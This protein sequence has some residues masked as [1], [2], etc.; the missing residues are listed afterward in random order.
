[1]KVIMIQHPHTF[2]KN[3]FAP[4]SMA[5]GF[6]D[7]VHEGH[8]SVILT[9]KKTADEQGANSAVMTFDPHPSVALSETG[10][11]VEYITPIED[12]I[13]FISGLGIDYL[14]I[15][16]FTSAFASLQPA[17][18][19]QQ[20]L[21]DLNV[22]YVT[23]GF[24]FTYGK[25]GKGT[26]ETLPE[27]GQG[28][29]QVVT[30]PKLE[31]YKEKVSSTWIRKLLRE[32]RTEEVQE[33][34]GRFYTTKGTV[35]HGE[36]R[37]RQLGFPTANIRLKNDYLVPKKGVYAV[38]MLVNDQWEKGVCNVG[39][40]PTFHE[41]G[42]MELSVEIHLLDFDRSIYGEEVTIE[43]RLRIRD[44]QKFDHLDHLKDQI[45][46]DKQTAQIFFEQDAK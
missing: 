15:V 35:I 31:R 23:A 27:H 5:L 7:G 36:K 38:R 40:K 44:E 32:G 19:V 14:L 34:L 6:F 18:F 1:M 11:D 22:Q 4:L 8:K 39:Y 3:D 26:M 10:G 46:K 28:K 41:P 20:Y 25:F 42:Q 24:D 43:W 37:G 9:A 45:L 12:K 33:L 17:E 13:E 29:L 30:V 21:L 16:R 2:Q